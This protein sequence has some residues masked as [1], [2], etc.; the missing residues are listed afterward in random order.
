[1]QFNEGDVGKSVGHLSHQAEVDQS[2]FGRIGYQGDF[3]GFWMQ[4]KG[5][6]DGRDNIKIFA[7]PG[8]AVVGIKMILEKIVYPAERA[9]TSL[10][11]VT[12]SAVVRS[13]RASTDP[14]VPSV[15]LIMALSFGKSRKRSEFMV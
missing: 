13:L 10:V 9:L 4:F 15:L 3:L 7:Y 5:N 12:N 14:K 8:V 2:G 1:M 6:L 11:K